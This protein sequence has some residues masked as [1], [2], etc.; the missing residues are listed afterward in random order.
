MEVFQGTHTNKKKI[1][2]K[3][4]LFNNTASYAQ[5]KKSQM[6]LLFYIIVYHATYVM[7]SN[8][9]SMRICYFLA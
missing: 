8:Q 6:Q 2:I 9:K 1:R 4:S 3:N 7:T 5:M